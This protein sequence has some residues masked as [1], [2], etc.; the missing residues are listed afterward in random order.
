MGE[1]TVNPRSPFDAP[2]HQGR[3]SL[4]IGKIED[5]L[6]EMN[7]GQPHEPD[8]ESILAIIQF[9]CGKVLVHK[10]G[11]EGRN[12]VGKPPSLP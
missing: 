12:I 3:M 4:L 5:I 6:V 2:K 8:V 11:F 7:D 10:E 1:G 9:G